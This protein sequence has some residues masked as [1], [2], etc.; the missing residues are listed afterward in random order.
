MTLGTL[1]VAVVACVDVE[2]PLRECNRGIMWPKVLS[3]PFAFSRTAE[4]M[5]WVIHVLEI[6]AAVASSAA[7]GDAV[8]E[9]DLGID[10]SRCGHGVASVRCLTCPMERIAAAV[11]CIRQGHIVVVVVATVVEVSVRWGIVG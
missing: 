6:V 2:G 8:L 1:A 9:G 7:G 3:V 4:S 11:G 5:L 10:I